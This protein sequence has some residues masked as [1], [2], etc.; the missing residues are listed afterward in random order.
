MEA[1][2][3]MVTGTARWMSTIIGVRF[4]QG[5]IPM[6]AGAIVGG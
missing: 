2:K 6:G 1:G 3:G 5:E 4:D